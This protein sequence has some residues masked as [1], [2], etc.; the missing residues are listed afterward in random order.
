[1]K[2]GAEALRHHPQLLFIIALLIVIPLLFL[3]SG[4]QFLDA[5]RENQDRLQKDK[6]GILHDVFA[7][8]LIATDFDVALMQQEI[9]RIARVNNNLND[10]RVVTIEGG[11]VSPIA[12]LNIEDVGTMRAGSGLPIARS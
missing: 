10:F 6:I 1:M 11:V 5:G 8:F 9:E 7:S 4:Q 2:A 3:Y 12:A